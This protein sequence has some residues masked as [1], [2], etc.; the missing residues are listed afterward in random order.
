ME[1]LVPHECQSC[2]VVDEA[3]FIFKGPHV[4]QLC[5]GC[6][7]YVKFFSKGHLPDVRE[8]RLRIWSIT[9]D[10]DKINLAKKQCKFVENMVGLDAKMVYWRLYLKIREMEA[11]NA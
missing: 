1:L 7:K 4:Q 8:I 2:G 3:K 5:N 11:A 9:Q 6:D 10:V